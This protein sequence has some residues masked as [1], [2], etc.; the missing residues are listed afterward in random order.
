MAVYH[1]SEVAIHERASL[2]PLYQHEVEDGGGCHAAEQGDEVFHVLP[3]VEGEDQ[4]GDVLHHHTEEE[5]YCHGEEYRQYDGE[6]LVGVEQLS[7]LQC[8][9]GACYLD[10]G[11]GNGAPQELEHQGDGCGSRHAERVEHVQED[12]VR[13]HHGKQYA[14]YLREIELRRLVDAV[15]RYVHH[16]VRE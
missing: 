1:I 7:Q 9:A 16:A 13:E 10:N 6:R 2:Q 14:H 4:S 11:N 8:P 12:H 3:I 15:T 5:G